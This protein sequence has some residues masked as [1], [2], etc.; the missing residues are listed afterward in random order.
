MEHVFVCIQ[1]AKLK[2]SNARAVFHLGTNLSCQFCRT[3]KHEVLAEVDGVP[4]PLSPLFKTDI[5]I[6]YFI[7]L[8]LLWYSVCFSMHVDKGHLRLSAERTTCTD[9]VTYTKAGRT[10]FPMCYCTWVIHSS[11]LLVFS[12]LTCILLAKTTLTIFVRNLWRAKI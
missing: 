11:R 10:V 4:L 5:K 7:K 3:F 8:L 9:F 1:H 6:K 12:M 2:L